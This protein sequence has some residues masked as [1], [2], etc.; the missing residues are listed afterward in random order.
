MGKKKGHKESDIERKKRLAL[1]KTMHTQ[2]VP[3]KTKYN[4]KGVDDEIS[5]Y[6]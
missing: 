3:D 2:V 6:Q 4:R 5:D 1:D